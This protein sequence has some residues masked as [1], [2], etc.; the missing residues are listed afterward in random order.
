ML[1]GFYRVLLGGMVLHS[2]YLHLD[3]LDRIAREDAAAVGFATQHYHDLPR[4]A[5]GGSLLPTAP[6]QM[7]GRAAAGRGPLPG[8]RERRRPSSS[9]DRPSSKATPLSHLLRLQL[10]GPV[11]SKAIHQLRRLLIHSSLMSLSTLVLGRM[12]DLF[13]SP[14]DT[15]SGYRICADFCNILR[16]WLCSYLRLL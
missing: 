9:H 5:A 15:C 10:S 11:R 1:R 6:R 3:L 13:G 8:H 7:P 14:R 4:R 16:L 2:F 12:T